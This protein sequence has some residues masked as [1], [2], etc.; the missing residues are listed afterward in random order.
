MHILQIIHGYPPDY[1]AGSE[2]YTQSISNELSKSHRV[3]VFT[4][5]ENPY[6]QDFEIRHVSSSQNLD[7]Y[8][9][10]NPQGKDGYRHKLL[11]NNFAKLLLEIKPDVAHIGHL[12]HLSTGIVDE[13]YKQQIPIVFT[14]HDFWLMCPR[15]QFLTRGIGNTNNY[16]LC[17][18]QND[19]KCANDCYKVYFSGKLE[20]ELTDSNNWS[21]W[22]N[23]RM[24][25][26]RS[27]VDKVNLFI[28]PSNYLRNRFINDFGIPERKIIYL[29]YGFPTHYLTQTTK[30]KDKKLFTFGYIGTH[31]PAKGVN[32]L[33]EAFK[34][35]EEPAILKIYGR[36]NGQNTSALKS[37]AVSSNNEIHFEG[38][39]I[40]HNL[41]NDVFSQVDCI[42]VPSIWAENSPLV[43]H[44]AQS[45]RIPVITADYG[46]MKEFVHHKVNGLLFEHRNPAALR[47]QLRFA[48]ANPELLKQYGE[49][50][51]L[52][53]ETSNVPDIEDHCT[54][55]EKIYT[56]VM[57]PRYL[58]RITLDTNPEDCN[59]KCVMCEEH[60][61]YSDFIPTLYRETG[62]KRRR[63][64]LETVEK[65]FLQ[66]KQLGVKEIIPST[67]GEPLMYQGMERI[68]AL[69]QEHNIKIN[70]T[71]N[72][73]FPKLNVK[74]WA[75]LIVPNTTDVKISLNGATRETAESVMQGLDFEKA[76][77][78][79][80]VLV[81]ERNTHFEKTGY[82]CRISFQLTFM[83]NNM[84]ELANI[85]K[86]AAELGVDR[87]KGHHLW[88]HF[89][90]IK[91][92]S[93]RENKV[94]IEKWNEYVKQAYI[95]QEKYQKP[96]GETVI[97]ENIIQLHDN[98]GQEV[99]EDYICPFLAKEL[100]ISATGD[101]SP[102]CAPDSLRK[103]LG[104]F[105]NIE[106]TSL[107][108]VLKSPTYLDLVKNYKSKSLCK[109][110]NMR[111]PA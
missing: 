37:L 67:M 24:A 25:E 45:C 76:I 99:P 60:S 53:S 111:K 32:Q 22:V 2:V 3:S 12:N 62:I 75:K 57:T 68:F 27:F 64:K 106:T 72:G 86:L 65:I 97:L 78:N 107:D 20:D 109:T 39:Y 88:T 105:G 96:S 33:I 93:M 14:L 87:V 79:V 15:G 34:Q 84:H 110:C 83:Q 80:K 16:Q 54:E 52:Y 92:L 7:F 19:H 69:S 77:E 58:W 8:Y 31:I 56:Q 17:E 41:A 10:N 13:L 102:C 82:Y 43:I 4:R 26:T 46:G 104:N 29:D 59:L 44:E 100:W 40:N 1:N 9:V 6:S 28:A 30:S 66:A 90:E 94:S 108:N 18:G 74:D 70:L 91:T 101:I 98:E 49:R 61:P 85:I 5:E 42:I 51:Y 38:E 23:S 63:M 48:I 55:L 81:S 11:D 103:S 50:G 47:E 95:A 36:H 71:T 35:I 21:S 89:E 73:T